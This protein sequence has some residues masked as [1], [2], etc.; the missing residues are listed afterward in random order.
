MKVKYLYT[1]M[2]SRF[3]SISS[4]YFCGKPTLRVCD[5][6]GVETSTFDH[7]CCLKCEKKQNELNEVKK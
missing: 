3:E 6:E 1:K 4:C 7:K 5:I 2:P